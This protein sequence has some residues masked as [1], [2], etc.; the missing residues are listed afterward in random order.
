M[1]LD[2]EDCFLMVQVKKLV[3]DLSGH[4]PLLLDCAVKEFNLLGNK[5]FR[6]DIDWLKH[7]SFLP[8]ARDIWSKPMY[9]SDPH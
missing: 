5:S 1:S 2:W 6:F 4:N 9:D 7:D 3:K 8:L